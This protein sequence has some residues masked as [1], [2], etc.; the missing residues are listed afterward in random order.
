VVKS[1]NRARGAFRASFL[2]S[3]GLALALVAGCGSLGGKSATHTGVQTDSAQ[4]ES[5]PEFTGPYASQFKD[6]WTQSKSDFVRSVIADQKI[7]DQEWAETVQRL[8]SCLK[9]KGLTFKGYQADGSYS[10]DNGQ[11]SP[12]EANAG[13]LP[14]ELQSGEHWIGLLRDQL[15][16]NPNNTPVGEIMAACLIR[17]KVVARGYTSDDY[18]R[19]VP[20]QSFP[21]LNPKTGEQD[22]R[23]CNDNPSIGLEK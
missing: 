22:Y 9:A 19:D 13:L 16:E 12:D 14:C 15:S 6:A 20:T 10:V 5:V 23:R 2:T 4:T 8:A 18:M 1:I 21:Y 17:L 3:S 7:S 11:L